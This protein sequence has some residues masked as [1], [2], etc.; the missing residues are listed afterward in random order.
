L[1]NVERLAYHGCDAAYHFSDYLFPVLRV[2]AGTLRILIKNGFISLMGLDSIHFD[3]DGC[4][5]E[6]S[7]AVLANGLFN[8]HY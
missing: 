6:S 3:L 7:L 8:D 4:Q 5:N 1:N 2:L